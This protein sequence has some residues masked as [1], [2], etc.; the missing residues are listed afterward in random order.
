MA[1]IS[2]KDAF[3][4][5]HNLSYSAVY[6]DQVL[7]AAKLANVKTE[8]ATR[9]A[10]KMIES[11]QKVGPNFAKRLQQ[12]ERV[13]K[14]ANFSERQIPALPPEFYPWANIRHQ[15][16]LELWPATNNTGCLFVIGHALGEFRNGLIIANLTMD[17]GKHLNID[18]S[19]QMN[20]VPKRLLD[21]DT[22][23]GRAVQI[24]E[25]LPT[26]TPSLTLL[27]PLYD[28]INAQIQTTTKLMQLPGTG[29]DKSFALNHKLLQILGNA[30][31]EIHSQ[32]S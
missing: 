3:Q 4:A 22:R 29:Q 12:V 17:F 13:S 5:G 10:N 7:L 28:G 20:A 30:E 9:H 32:L 2:Q 26:P 19:S 1:A 23:F 8:N 18:L 14:L 16:Y 15:E 27:R 21:A 24:L 6:F 25:N 11:L 31:V